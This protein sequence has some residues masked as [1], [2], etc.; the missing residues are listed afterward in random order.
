MYYDPKGTVTK[1]LL[2]SLLTGHYKAKY[3]GTVMLGTNLSLISG[4]GR[5]MY[6]V[7]I[8]YTSLEM[9]EFAEFRRIKDFR[10]NGEERLGFNDAYC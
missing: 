9:K 4:T 8:Q 1:R 10:E 2:Q 6:W 7:R 3:Q 5:Q